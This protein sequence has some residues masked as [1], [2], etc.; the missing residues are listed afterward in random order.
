MNKNFQQTRD[1]VVYATQKYIHGRVLDF[2]AG[3]AK[4]KEIIK[5]K[6]DEYIAFDMITGSN[7]DVVGDVMHAP[8]NDKSF[9]TVVSTQVLEHVEKPWTVVEEMYRILKKNG[10]C[11]ATAPFMGPYHADPKDFFRYTVE[12]MKSLFQNSGFEIVESGSYGKLFTVLSE[13]IRFSIFNPYK[14]QKR[15][16]WRI[17]KIVDKIGKLLNRL[18]KNSIIYSAVYMIAKKV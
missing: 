9:D 15:G 11:I 7:I 18:T 4:Y 10:I 5:E 13:F 16:N 17:I 6:S 1:V 8:F 2:G 14:K 3:S 12:G